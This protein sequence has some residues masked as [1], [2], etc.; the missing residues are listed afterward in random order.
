MYYIESSSHDA[1]W[2][3]ALEEYVLRTLSDKHDFFMLW[4][5]RNAIVVGRFQNTVA[6]VNSAHVSA[7]GTQVVRRLSGGGAMYQDLGNLNFTFVVKQH[8]S[9]VL[10]FGMFALPVIDALRHMGVDAQL[11]GR[12]DIVVDD[13]KI[14]GNAQFHEKGRTLHHGT[15]LFNSDLDSIGEALVVSNAKIQSKGV[16]SVRSRVTNILPHMATPVSIEAFKIILHERMFAHNALTQYTLTEADHAA[17]DTLA[18]EKYETW[19]WNYGKSPAYSMTKENRFPFGSVL[20]SL[21]ADGG[22]LR[23]LSIWG[24]FF[25]NGDMET[26]CQMLVGTALSRRALSDVLATCDLDQYIAGIRPD[27]LIELML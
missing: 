21:D 12:N 8:V 5:N 27:Q 3:M 1:F 10:D 13:K 7:H 2:N 22:V 26:L 6:E 18:R 14:S 23:N 4:Q 19:D 9:K 24:D 15:L 17:I 16:S 11:N 20:V 25:G